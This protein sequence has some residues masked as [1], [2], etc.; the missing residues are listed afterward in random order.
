MKVFWVCSFFLANRRKLQSC[1]L[2]KVAQRH[3]DKTVLNWRDYTFESYKR[4]RVWFRHFISRC[5]LHYHLVS[6]HFA[7]K[8]QSTSNIFKTQQSSIIVAT[9]QVILQVRTDSLAQLE[10]RPQIKA[11]MCRCSCYISLGACFG[12][13]FPFKL[14]CWYCST[15]LSVSM[16]H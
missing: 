7:T 14:P 13:F 10:S 15:Y 11:V 9:K 1:Y 6:Q 16:L 8:N 5:L 2:Y 3:V 4:Y 12:V